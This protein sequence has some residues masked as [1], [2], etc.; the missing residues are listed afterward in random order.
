MPSF[1]YFLSLNH[2]LTQMPT[3]HA[4]SCYSMLNASMQNVH[5][6]GSLPASTLAL[7]SKDTIIMGFDCLSLNLNNWW[8]QYLLHYLCV[9]NIHYRA[10]LE[11]GERRRAQGTLARGEHLSVWLMTE[12]KKYLIITLEKKKKEK[13]KVQFSQPYRSN[14]HFKSFLWLY[15]ICPLFPGRMA[16]GFTVCA[17]S[18]ISNQIFKSLHAWLSNLIFDLIV[19]LLTLS[20]L[21]FVTCK[22]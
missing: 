19:F 9:V 10:M 6:R 12:R 11:I 17:S 22:Y 18:Q 7:L 14:M 8:L 16:L 21:L 3:G 5:R 2:F 1:K 15:C 4:P 20:L 13:K